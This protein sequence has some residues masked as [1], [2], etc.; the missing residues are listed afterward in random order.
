MIPKT[1][2]Y[3]WFGGNPLPELAQKCL[4]SWKKYCPD[5]ELMRWDESNFDVNCCDY[6][7]EAYA[8]KKWA[9]VSDY[10]RLKALV[11]FGG[12]YMD[13]DMEVLRP[14]D[15]FLDNEAFA[16]LESRNAISCG[17]MGCQKGF[18]PFAEI[19][20]EYNNKHFYRLGGG[21]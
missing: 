10:A 8:A 7:R 5:Y 2:H 18:V 15:E 9:F 14:I 17:I 21:Y 6:V 11:D 19:M 3:C 1:I 13:T 12:V 20:E 16:G 4:A